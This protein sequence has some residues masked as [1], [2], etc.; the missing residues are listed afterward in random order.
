MCEFP[1]R[2]IAWL[3]RELPDEESAAVERHLRMCAECRQR[4]SDYEEVGSAFASYCDR[5]QT[6]RLM[7][8]LPLWAPLVAGAGVAALLALWFVLPRSPV[9]QL[10]LRPL[11]VA[12][13]PAIAFETAPVAARVVY[14]RVAVPP[15]QNQ[16]TPWRPTEPA[17]QIVIPAD[18]MF[19]PGAVPEG[20]SFVANVSIGPD[21]SPQ[22]LRLRP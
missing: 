9:Q 18:G 3:D 2:L 17:V 21:G 12:S 4:V 13:A 22:A 19:P 1:D 7:R 5:S 10:P 14:R 16:E 20:F 6:V 8:R 11:P 15:A